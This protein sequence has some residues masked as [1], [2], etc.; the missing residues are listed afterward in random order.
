MSTANATN[1]ARLARQRAHRLGLHFH[2]TGAMGT[3]TDSDGT[4][5]AQGPLDEVNAYL[6]ARSNPR[7][8]GP[9]PITSAPPD[10]VELV[11]EYLRTLSAAGQRPGSIRLRRI[12]LYRMARE[13][14]CP[15]EGVTSAALLG[16]FGRQQDW[17]PEA[18]HSY[19]CAVRGF[20]GWAHKFDRTPTNY[21]AVLPKVRIP[22][23]PPRPASD[24]AW[25]TAMAAASPRV[26]LMLRLAGEAGLRRAEVAQV[27]THDLI[28]LDGR[29]NLIVNGKGG[30][31]RVLPITASL[32]DEIRAGAA[33]HTA[34][35]QPRGYLF[36]DGSGGHITADHVGRMVKMVL[37]PG[38]TM[39]QLRHRF[40]TKA[41]R[42]SG[43]LR[44]VQDLLG[45]ESV[46]TTQRYTAVDGDELRAAML[47]ASE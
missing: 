5:L 7:P 30:K 27:H 20:F 35:M 18:R 14:N 1:A 13:L 29:P 33:G 38:W 2:Q 10:W 44:A 41:Y 31:R 26:R 25:S 45:H 12:Q 36:P 17:S 47:A 19:R 40:A 6:V 22:K 21:A 3:L 39:H 16:W 15:P 46:A 9:A 34:G 11:D 24:Q 37:P 8:S 4:V 42:G 28:D 23:A 32:A 43:N